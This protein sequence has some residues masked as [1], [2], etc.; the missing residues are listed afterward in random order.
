MAGYLK[1]LNMRLLHAPFDSIGLSRIVQLINKTNQFN[2][3]TKRYDENAVRNIMEDPAKLTLQFRL[4]DKMGDNGMISVII[5][6]LDPDKNLRID[7]WLMSCRV[8]GRDVEQATLN[9]LCAQ[10]L[11]LGAGRLIGEY[12]PTP[13]NGMVREHYRKLGFQ[14]LSEGADGASQWTFGLSSFKNVLLS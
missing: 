8:L 10:A 5:A 13:K 7:T 14:L 2:L 1:S 9:V 11:T 3:T 6:C 12:I 4:V